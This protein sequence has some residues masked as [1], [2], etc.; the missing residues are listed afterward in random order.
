MTDPRDLGGDIVGPG[1]PFGEGDVVLDTSKAVL[2]DSL[3][4]AKVDNPSDGR[5]VVA[6]LIGG[7][8]NQS[9]DRASVMVLGNLDMLASF[10][11]EAHGL[12]ERMGQ[13]EELFRLCDARWADMPQKP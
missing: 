3:N 2:M 5:E 11:T 9:P 6:M 10:I 4:V 12:A 8:I 1:G 13:Q 7:R